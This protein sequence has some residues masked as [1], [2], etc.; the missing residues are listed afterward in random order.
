MINRRALKN[1]KPEAPRA[2]STDVETAEVSGFA[3]ATQELVVRVD[4][5]HVMHGSYRVA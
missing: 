2:L 3:I 4:V 1:K 5:E